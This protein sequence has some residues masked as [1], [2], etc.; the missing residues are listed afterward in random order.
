MNKGLALQ[1]C[2]VTLLG[3]HQR[4]LMLQVACGNFPVGDQGPHQ[5]LVGCWVHP[6]ER[7][8][9]THLSP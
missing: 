5:R 8:G 3:F 6:P 2:L 7:M 4:V 9:M 1:Q